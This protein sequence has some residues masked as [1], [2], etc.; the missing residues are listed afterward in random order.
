[1]K[2]Y[3]HIKLAGNSFYISL[4]IAERV[5]IPKRWSQKPC[6]FR[7][8]WS[9]VPH[10]R[11]PDQKFPGLPQRQSAGRKRPEQ[12]M[13]NK[14]S[15]EQTGSQSHCQAKYIEVSYFSLI[16][17]LKLK[18]ITFPLLSTSIKKPLR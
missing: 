13:D 15:H 6:G 5:T 1:L 11:K 8:L 10:C 16:F 14:S 17:N 18:L 9:A 3:G 7:F 12:L 4:F 2:K